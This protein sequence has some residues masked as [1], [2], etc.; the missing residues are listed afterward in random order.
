MTTTM[1]KFHASKI[2]GAKSDRPPVRDYGSA[3]A[4]ATLSLR[5]VAERRQT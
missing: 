5:L 2:E 4:I 1:S 3:S